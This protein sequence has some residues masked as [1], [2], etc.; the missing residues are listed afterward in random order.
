MAL[1]VYTT[2]CLYYNLLLLT[3]TIPLVP[4][5]HFLKRYFVHVFACSHDLGSHGFGFWFLSSYSFELGA[6]LVCFRGTGSG[7]CSMTS[8]QDPGSRGA[9][10]RC[11]TAGLRGF[12]VRI[13]WFVFPRHGF[14]FLQHDFSS[15][16]QFSQRVSAMRHGRASRHGRSL[17]SWFRL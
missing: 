16:S 14:G 13:P 17:G 2:V 8:G 15:R 5:G 9:F 3:I 4:N 1:A 10:P 12:R 7:F 11:G 6:G